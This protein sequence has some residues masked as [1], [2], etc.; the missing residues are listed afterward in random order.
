MVAEIGIDKKPI[1]DCYLR[2]KFLF[3]LRNTQ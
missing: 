1:S 3:N 2:R